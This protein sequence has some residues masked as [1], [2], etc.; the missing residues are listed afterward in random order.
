LLIETK[1]IAVDVSIQ[2]IHRFEQATKFGI[3]RRECRQPFAD[4]LAFPPPFLADWREL[5]MVK[6]RSNVIWRRVRKRIVREQ[7][8]GSWIIVQKFPNKMQCPRV[9]LG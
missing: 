4:C 2:P 9:L 1:F 3:L 6:P 8:E 5:V 7:R